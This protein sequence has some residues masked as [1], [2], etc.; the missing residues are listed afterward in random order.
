MLSNWEKNYDVDLA[1]CPDYED[2]PETGSCWNC[3]HMVEVSIGGKTYQLCVKERD[4]SAAGDVEVAD[5]TT[6]NCE[7]WDDY[8]A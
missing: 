6:R 1:R 7:D 8:S 5:P 4:I 3:D 2:E